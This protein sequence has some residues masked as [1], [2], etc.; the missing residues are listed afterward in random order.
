MY[1][2][3]CS[4]ILCAHA[5]H[6]TPCTH[7]CTNTQYST[8]YTLHI[9]QHKS[10]GPTGPSHSQCTRAF[11]S[12]NMGY[13]QRHTASSSGLGHQV[14]S[15]GLGSGATRFRVRYLIKSL[16]RLDSIT[17]AMYAPVDVASTQ[18]LGHAE[19]QNATRELDFSD[20]CSRRL[21]LLTHL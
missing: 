17:A 12:G 19:R 4:S 5:S 13:A 1:T 11:R 8:L 15:S 6:S 18:S 16:G 21:D 3:T 14:S 20:L 2:V 10:T 9:E 7:P